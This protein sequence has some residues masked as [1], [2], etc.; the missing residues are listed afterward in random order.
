MRK[1]NSKA[2]EIKSSSGIA[3]RYARE[4]PEREAGDRGRRLRVTHNTGG[5]CAAREVCKASR[6]SLA[7]RQPRYWCDLAD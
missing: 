7:G 3:V 4:L 5:H 1:S 6:P 2:V